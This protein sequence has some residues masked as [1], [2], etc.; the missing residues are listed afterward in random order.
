MSVAAYDLKWRPGQHFFVRLFAFG[1][2]A[3]TSHPFTAANMPAQPA[4]GVSELVF[5]ARPH[6]GISARL[7]SATAS[8]KR[9]VIPVS[10]DGPYGGLPR[11]I[12]SYDSVVLLAG[13]S[14]GTFLLP[15]FQDLVRAL[16]DER[17]TTRATEIL[18]VW[19][20][21]RAGRW[22]CFRSIRE[23]DMFVGVIS[24]DL[25]WFKE[26]AEAIAASAPRD[27]TTCTLRFHVTSGDS[28]QSTPKHHDSLDSSEL[29]KADHYNAGLATG[30]S[31]GRPDLM[32]IIGQAVKRPGRIAICG[33]LAFL[34]LSL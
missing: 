17:D 2:H 26:E 6:S 14:G 28:G 23:T 19:A 31:I 32:Q 16:S 29:V 15:I 20:T 34:L 12:R 30:T 9:L 27:T 13:G 22:R 5:Y 25:A 24:D 33:K 18:V 3:F 8:G 1:P 11:S 7:A 10:L 4:R 21:R